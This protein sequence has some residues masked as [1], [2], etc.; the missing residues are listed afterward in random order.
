MANIILYT[1]HCPKCKILRSKLD[2]NN[3]SYTLCDDV[4]QMIKLNIHSA[5]V[6]SVDGTLNDFITAMR[7]TAG[8]T[9]K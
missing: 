6:L 4:E 2:D 3:I 7:L 1:T 9:L 8:G 5:P